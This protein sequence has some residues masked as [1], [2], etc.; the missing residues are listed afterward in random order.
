MLHR[1]GYNEISR[2]ITQRTLIVKL[3]DHDHDANDSSGKSESLS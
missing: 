1:V 3:G 2:L